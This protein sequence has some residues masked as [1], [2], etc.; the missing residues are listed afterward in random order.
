MSIL[1]KRPLPLVISILLT[2]CAALV[3]GQGDASANLLLNGNVA[4]DLIRVPGDV[5]TIADAVK[6][7]SDGGT[8]E[9]QGGEYT[10]AGA[11]LFLN[12]LNK[13]FTIRAVSGQEVILKGNGS[14]DILRVQNTPDQE[15]RN[16]IIFDG[17]T[18][19]GGRSAVEGVAGGVTIHRVRVDFLNCRFVDNQG[20]QTTTGGGA[21]AIGENA[22]VTLTNCTFENNSAQNEGGAIGINSNAKVSISS[23]TFTNNRVDLPNHR[24]TA[25]GGA[26]HIGNSTVYITNSVFTGNR[27]G[28]VGG[29]LYAIGT[30]AD[31]V[32]T[33]RALVYITGS[34]FSRNVAKR[35]PSVNFTSPTE[36]GGVHFEDQATGIIRNSVF[37][38]NE[39][40]IGA[41][42]NLYRATVEVYESTFNGNRTTSTQA[43]QGFGGA[44]SATSNDGNDSTTGGGTINR[45]SAHLTIDKTLIIGTPDSPTN[46]ANGI[47]VAGDGYRV[48]GLGGVPQMGSVSENRAIVNITNSMIYDTDVQDTGV[49]GTGIGGGITTDLAHITMEDV[50][51]YGAD[52]KGSAN[53]SGGGMALLNQTF[54]DLNRITVAKS[55]SGLYG[56]GILVQGSTMNLSNC[57][58]VDNEIS[59]GVDE[60]VGQSF[61]AALFSGPDDGRKLGVDGTVSNCIISDNIGLPIFD[62]DRQNG[63]VNEMRYNNNQIFST[64]FGDIV[65]T[66]SIPFQCC[67]TVAEL[68][69][70]IVPRNTGLPMTTKSQSPNIHLK[71]KPDVGALI[72]LVNNTLGINAPPYLL[73][74]AWSGSSATLD[75]TALG[76][77]G[78]TT[79][80]STAVSSRKLSR[81]ITHTLLVGRNSISVNLTRL[82]EYGLFLPSVVR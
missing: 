28:Y 29:A 20:R 48:Y 44:I 11:P 61:G 70:L 43:G 16:R 1:W 63:P 5:A 62:D 13:S 82:D 30:W 75:G 53:A 32:S 3:I 40:N 9:I 72:P 58:L 55:S 7:V 42:V 41:G 19:S 56:G 35:D 36:G 64:T 24:N 14:Q 17:L 78:G 10:S 71:V 49:P 46:S 45:P 37:N 67:K 77:N 79:L 27:A 74:W 6:A 21:L 31:P 26:I 76:V 47:Y 68:N 52:A 33:P 4:R 34:T 12:N 15:N 81:T 69:T 59:P 51:V 2:F 66:D 73:A 80:I 38:N 57:L 50:I 22:I 60:T 18:F 39:A 25:A 8:I 23:S 65:Y 54:A